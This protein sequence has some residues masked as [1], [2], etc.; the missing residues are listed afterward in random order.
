MLLS[1]DAE[2]ATKDLK[3]RGYAVIPLAPN[4]GLIQWLHGCDTMHALI[5]EYRDARKVLLNIEHRLMLQMAPDHTLLTL[6]QKVEVFEVSRNTRHTSAQSPRC[7]FEP[8][9]LHTR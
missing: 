9:S 4:S 3:I 6:I 2:T 5:K 7:L 1:R 8:K